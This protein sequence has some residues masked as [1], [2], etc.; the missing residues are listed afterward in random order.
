MSSSTCR[1]Q[2]SGVSE[3]S[4]RFVGPGARHH[5]QLIMRLCEKSKSRVAWFEANSGVSWPL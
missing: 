3:H 2:S 1:G 4:F 5:Q